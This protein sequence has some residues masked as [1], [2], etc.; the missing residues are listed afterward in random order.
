MLS[1][2]F[3][4]SNAE[5][6]T[7]GYGKGAAVIGRLASNAGDPIS[8]ASLC[9]STQTI[10]ID[11]RAAS[12]GSVKTDANGRYRFEVAPGPNREVVIGYRHDTAQVAREV[13]YYA[14]VRPSLRVNHERVGNGE[15]VR[16]TGRLPG[17]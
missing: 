5:Q 4:R 10:G 9:V 17:P 16:F 1:A 6:V 14:R 13:R 11:R 8:G 12:A 15:R 7:V 3:A 2:Q